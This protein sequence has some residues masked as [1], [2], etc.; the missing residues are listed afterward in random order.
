[1]IENFKKLLGI[2]N[3]KWIIRDEIEVYDASYGMDKPHYRKYLLQCEHCGNLKN[4]TN[5]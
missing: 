4:H 1:M 3:H 2:C 5:K